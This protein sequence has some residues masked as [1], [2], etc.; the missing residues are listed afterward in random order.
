MINKV[1]YVFVFVSMQNISLYGAFRVNDQV[2]SGISELSALS[3]L[4]RNEQVENR[5]QL[6]ITFLFEN[7]IKRR[8]LMHGLKP[9]TMDN[10]TNCIVEQSNPNGVLDGFEHAELLSLMLACQR[11]VNSEKD[12]SKK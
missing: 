2:V 10:I 8:I 12:I 3:L 4:E 9:L 6:F 11:K 1:L 5:K 7:N